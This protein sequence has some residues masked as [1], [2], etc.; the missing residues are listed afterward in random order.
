MTGFNRT[1]KNRMEGDEMMGRPRR[2]VIM[3]IQTTGV[4]EEGIVCFY[5]ISLNS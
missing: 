1:G 2:F 3:E 4:L 5:S